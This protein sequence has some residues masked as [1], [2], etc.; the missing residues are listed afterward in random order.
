MTPLR[1]ILV[2]SDLTIDSDIPLLG[3]HHLAQQAGADLHVV[4]VASEW[5]S[6]DPVPYRRLK[7]QVNRAIAD[8]D[9]TSYEV[10]HDRPFHGILVQAAKVHADLVV[11]GRT[12]QSTV[13]NRVTST[14][15]ERIVKSSDLPCLVVKT[16]IAG[17]LDRYGILLDGAVSDRGSVDLLSEWLPYFST[18]PSLMFLHSSSSDDPEVKAAMNA[19]RRYV[20]DRL[21]DRADISFSGLP[22]ADVTSAAVEWARER[23]VEGLVATTSARTGVDRL[24]SGSRAARLIQEAPCSVLLV[25]M[26]FWRR[27]PIHLDR[28]AVA[29]DDQTRGGAPHR[30]IQDRVRTA[31]QEVATIS[32]DPGGDWIDDA[33]DVEADLLVVD[34]MHETDDAGASKAKQ[35]LPSRIESTLER[36]PLPVLI[37]RDLPEGPI[38]NVL[39]AVDTGELWYEKLGWAKR[40]YDRFDSHITV[41]HA[42]DLSIG[43]KVRR[44]AGGEFVAGPSTWMRDDVERTVVPAMHAWLRERVRLSGLPEDHVD[45]K[46]SLSDPWYAIPTL[47]LTSGA[48]LVVVAAHSEPGPEAAPLSPVARAVLEGGDYSVLAVVDRAR[49]A[50]RWVESADVPSTSKTSTS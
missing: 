19:T 16:P 24:W 8:A 17:S 34:G 47:A 1:S 39:V 23:A 28:V 45:V 3:A 36:T 40:W 27:S 50:R 44:V 43:S 41:F 22:G 5:E 49:A 11:L 35:K 15:A 14:T 25:P 48:D 31:S 18:D 46:V 13:S 30:W 33:W 6:H 42:I 12:Q 37:L 7:A 4:H 29:V 32:I 21:T 9:L 10:V 38:Q 2:A 20:K 26:S